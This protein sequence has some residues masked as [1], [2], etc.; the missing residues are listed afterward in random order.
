AMVPLLFLTVLAL[1][2]KQKNINVSA[3]DLAG[4]HR[5]Q[6]LEAMLLP[7]GMHEI[8]SA[9]SVA[10][11][12]AVEKLQAA[13]ADVG[14]AV[15]AQDSVTED[16]GAPAGEDAR[17]WSEIKVAWNAITAG[18]PSSVAEVVRLHSELRREILDYRDYIA[19]TS[20]LVL[21]GDPV[22]FFMIDAT[23]R[24]IPNY[25]SYVTEMR[26]H[27]AA[28][29]A[30]GKATL[31]DIEQITRSEVLAQGALDDIAA[32]IRHAAEGGQAG[33][34]MR[35]R[36]EES[37]G[38]VKSAFEAFRKY[39]KQNVISG[40]ISD[41]LDDVIFNAAQLTSAISSFHSSMQATSQARLSDT[42]SKLRGSRTRMILLVGLALTVGIGFMG[43]VA[44]TTVGGMLAAV[45]V[46]SRLAE[47]NYA[48]EIYVYGNDEVARI[49]LALKQMQSKL[50]G[51]LSGV[52]E[53]AITVATAARQIK[54]GTS[55]LSSRTEQQAAN[56]EETASSIEEMTTTVKQNADNAKLAN[57]LAQA[58]R[59]QAEHGGQ[60]VEQAVSAMGAIDIA[61]KRISDIIS[62]IDEIAF[63]TNL[64][65]LNAAVEA[66]RA[67]D[68]G[69][70]FAVVASE[71]RSLA[72]RSASAAKEI[73]DLIHDSVGKV[74]EGSRLVSESGRH[75]HEIVASVKKVSD[76]VGEISNAS[77]EQAAS[78][79]EISRAVMQMDESTQQNAAMVEEAN[80]AAASM[81]DQATRLS[82]LTSFFKLREGNALPARTAE[83]DAYK[84]SVK[85]GRPA[86]QIPAA[87]RPSAVFASAAAAAAHSTAPAADKPAAAGGGERP[88]RRSSARPWVGVTPLVPPPAPAPA[89]S[90]S[91]SA[92]LRTASTASS[93]DWSEF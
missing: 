7:V 65:A 52:K 72:Q 23:V 62:V 12:G 68:Q 21:D 39:V 86:P 87:A 64:L 9:A 46:V 47:G 75:L 57:K 66:A 93:N 17:R 89:A 34:V 43:T 92:K 70:G 41:P 50:S 29:G 80:A 38:Q 88:E 58:A 53:S 60:V 28:V 48:R 6:N 61:S 79:D 82:E 74:G 19:T 37:I 25:E 8:W 67:G 49:M 76:V 84:V 31:A 69:R 11:E 4:L 55:D 40:S 1:S 78:A 18:K 36:A 90:T 44:W 20:G 10:G 26:S 73:K 3:R 45:T 54:A 13:T 27:A 24:Q 81:N 59:D 56:L 42:L 32:D 85:P 30:A 14:K 2:D 71:V 91:A 63:Q 16:Y 15:A 77:Q 51:V 35:S 33:E 22:T 5:Y 83:A